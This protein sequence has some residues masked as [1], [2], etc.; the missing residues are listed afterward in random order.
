MRS[1]AKSP[2]C[3]W[4]DGQ[5]IGRAQIDW[6]LSPPTA[7][8]INSIAVP[9][10]PASAA[11][12]PHLVLSA[13]HPITLA[14]S[15]AAGDWLT[16]AETPAYSD[17]CR[18]FLPLTVAHNNLFTCAVWFL[19]SSAK[20]ATLNQETAILCTIRHQLGQTYDDKPEK[21]LLKQSF[22]FGLILCNIF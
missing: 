4:T 22:L 3:G 14:S 1:Q 11:P 13:P 15:N 9:P 18:L 10:P 6:K 16:A 5:M 8:E 2:K 20:I 7:R 17:C 21:K 12:P 19:R